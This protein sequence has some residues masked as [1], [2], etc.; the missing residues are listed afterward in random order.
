MKRLCIAFI[1]AAILVPAIGPVQAQVPGRNTAFGVQMSIGENVDL[2]IGGRF[3]FSLEGVVEKLQGTAT[4]NLFFPGR[5]QSYWSL[6]ANAL[7]PLTLESGVVMTPYAGAGLGI[8]HWTME[9]DA[10]SGQDRSETKLNLNLIAGTMIGAREKVIPFVEIRLP[11]GGFDQVG[12]FVTG[13][14]WF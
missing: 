3:G 14:V 9:A 8:A 7:Y 5:D 4:L 10:A 1:S 12:F 6:N 13:G 2:G 11:L